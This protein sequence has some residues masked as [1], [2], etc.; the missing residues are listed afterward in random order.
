MTNLYQAS[1]QWRN[2]PVDERFASL[3]EMRAACK[4]Y[5]DHS[6]SKDVP[7]CDLRVEAIKP[8]PDSKQADLYLVGKTNTP[9]RLS[10]YAFDQLCSR[11]ESPA[12]F[13]SNLPPTLTANILNHQLFVRSAKGKGRGMANV[14]FHQ[15]GDLVARAITTDMYRRIWNYTILDFLILLRDVQGWRTPPARPAFPNQPGTRPATEADVLFSQGDFGLSVKVGDPIADSALYAS[16]HDM[17]A[18]MVNEVRIDDG[19]DQGLGR[20]FFCR[21]SEVGDC[22]I[23]FT[24]FLYRYVCGNHIVWGAQDIAEFKIRHVGDVVNAI[25]NQVPQELERY[26]QSGVGSIESSI[27]AARQKQLGTSK[28]SVISTVAKMKIPALSQKR[29]EQAYNLAEQNIDE[30]GNPFSVWAMANGITRL[31]QETGFSDKRN[32]LDRATGVMMNK[33]GFTF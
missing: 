12:P 14:L 5:A 11:S 22:S 19:S 26:S 32:E 33:L 6:I 2:R 10:Y 31:S 27:K 13:L 18:F 1:N 20:G 17:F 7:F 4:S 23:W 21:Q 28:E 15:N 3:E 25:A 9:A 8:N 24:T 16:I 29:I 30:D